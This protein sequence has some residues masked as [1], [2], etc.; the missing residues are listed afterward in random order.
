MLPL[1][2]TVFAFIWINW[3][4]V[5]EEFLKVSSRGL[6]TVGEESDWKEMV[7]GNGRLFTYSAHLDH[8]LKP[9]PSIRVSILA[10]IEQPSFVECSYWSVSNM[11][12]TLYGHLSILPNSEKRFISSGVIICPIPK[13]PKAISE[14]KADS[15]NMDEEGQQQLNADPVARVTVSIIKEM[16]K[17]YSASIPVQYLSGR[18]KTRGVECLRQSD[19]FK[20][21][22]CN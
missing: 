21:Q 14:S 3:K 1:T 22:Q 18:K 15:S 17:N 20:L 10:P 16:S 2:L 11:T 6:N 19:A 5:Q 8:R 4:D 12:T 7:G 9:D 13:F